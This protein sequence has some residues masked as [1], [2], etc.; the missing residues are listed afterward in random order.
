MKQPP[1]S[2]D[3]SRNKS[4]KTPWPATTEN[5]ISASGLKPI[6][7]P[8]TRLGSRAQIPS[9]PTFLSKP[10]AIV[11]APPDVAS[12][13]E[14]LNQNR[15]TQAAERA[16]QITKLADAVQTNN[17]HPK[18]QV[19]IRTFTIPEIPMIKVVGHSV[20]GTK[21]IP[22]PSLLP[23]LSHGEMQ[24]TLAKMVFLPLLV[25]IATSVIG[26]NALK[27]DRAPS[28]GEIVDRVSQRAMAPNR[29]LTNPYDDEPTRVRIN[30]AGVRTYN[31]P[32]LQ[33]P[34]AGDLKASNV[35]PIL[36]QKSNWIKIAT[37]QTHFAWVNQSSVELI[38]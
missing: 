34:V 24:K 14:E 2:E 7:R 37:D 16:E 4:K 29:N 20:G 12:A 36:E 31:G 19:P 17:L 28:S 6:I 9:R 35:Y 1:T 38:R 26:W 5:T 13:I 10:T 25:L 27:Q 15:E 8:S 30:V 22:F 3:Q 23:E 21:T 11:A 32:G 33:F 18:E